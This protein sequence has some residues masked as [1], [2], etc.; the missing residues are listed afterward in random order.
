MS[1]FLVCVNSAIILLSEV[2]HLLLKEL[3]FSY[4]EL[5]AGITLITLIILYYQNVYDCFRLVFLC[6]QSE[7]DT[8]NTRR[9]AGHEFQTGSKGILRGRLHLNA[10]TY[11][12][13]GEF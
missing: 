3:I 8:A 1:I 6:M 4:R 11:R 13:H 12:S 5:V 9:R 2:G 7:F 10:V